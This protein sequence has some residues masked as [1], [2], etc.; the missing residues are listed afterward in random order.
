MIEVIVLYFKL[1]G[2]GEENLFKREFFN[3]NLDFSLR[4]VFC[5]LYL[6]IVVFF[7]LGLIR[8]IFSFLLKIV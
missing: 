8:V 1:K 4:G 5:K 3:S 6:K 7:A 2:K